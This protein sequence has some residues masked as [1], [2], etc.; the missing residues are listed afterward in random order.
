MDYDTTKQREFEL[1]QGE[2]SVT[3]DCRNVQERL[4]I[5][6]VFFNVGSIFFKVFNL[7]RY[8]FANYIFYTL[9]QGRLLVRRKARSCRATLFWCLILNLGAWQ[10]KTIFFR[11]KSYQVSELSVPT[12]VRI[13]WLMLYN[14]A[15]QSYFH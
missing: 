5:R 1:G 9:V 14:Y 13:L 6:W 8:I 3:L 15:S 10:F 12:N 11:S 7:F 4:L 2:V